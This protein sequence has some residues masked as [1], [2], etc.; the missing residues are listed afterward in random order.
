[1]SACISELL[2][3]QTLGD[4]RPQE[5]LSFLQTNVASTDICE[6]MLKE[7]FLSQMSGTIFCVS[8]VSCIFMHLRDACIKAFKNVQENPSVLLRVFVSVR[9]NNKTEDFR[10]PFFYQKS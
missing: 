4:S 10:Q 2:N 5:L 3:P 9:W 1:M 7:L 8:Y 6:Y